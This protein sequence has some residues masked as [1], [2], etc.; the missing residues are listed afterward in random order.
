MVFPAGIFSH[1]AG[2]F[3]F[4]YRQNHIIYSSAVLDLTDLIKQAVTINA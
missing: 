3:I 1:R 2:R 4:P